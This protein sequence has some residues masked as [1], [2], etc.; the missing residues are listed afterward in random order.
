MKWLKVKLNNGGIYK[1]HKILNNKIH[2]YYT[3]QTSKQ[4]AIYDFVKLIK[5]YCIIKLKIINIFLQTRR[6]K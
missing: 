3:W 6:V 4:N 2:T 1:K 5:P